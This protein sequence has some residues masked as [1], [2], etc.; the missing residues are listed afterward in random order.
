MLAMYLGKPLLGQRIVDVMSCLEFLERRPDVDATAV[1]LVAVGR[2][3]PIGLH[4]AYLDPRIHKLVL[5]D[6]IRSWIDDVVAKPLAP[7]LL[8]Q[9]VP[10]A[11]AYYD[12]TDLEAALADR[13][14]R[15]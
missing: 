2:A 7:H 14:E 5:K 15:Q 3:G 13:V 8:A 6:S 10:G 11:L 1:A 12:L 4:A 9:V